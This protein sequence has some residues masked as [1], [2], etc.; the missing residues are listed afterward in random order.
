MK[1]L[2]LAIWMDCG[3][4]LGGLLRA[5]KWKGE[6]LMYEGESMKLF[7]LAKSGG[8]LIERSAGGLLQASE[9]KGM[10]GMHEEETI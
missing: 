9:G 5:A 1:L 7:G 8:V 2:G 10:G 4:R 6:G 3:E